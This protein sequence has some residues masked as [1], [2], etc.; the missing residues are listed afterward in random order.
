MMHS[1]SRRAVLTVGAVTMALS[2]L[3]ACGSSSSSAQTAGT[4]SNPISLSMGIEPWIGY[5]PWYIAQ[6][7]GYFAKHGLKVNIVNFQTDADRNAAL[8]SGKTEVS[9]IDAGR[10][11][12]FKASKQPGTP[13]F[14]LDASLGAD[15]I[16]AASNITDARGLVGK[17]VDYEYGTTSD[18]LLHYY[19]L[20]NK[21]NPN[22]VKSNNVPAANAGT[23]LIAGKTPVAVTYQPYITN[24]TQGAN[25]SKA[26]ILFGSDKA[27]GLISDFVTA[28]SSWLASHQ[29]VT[30][31]LLAAWDDAVNFYNTHHDQAVKIMAKGVGATPASLTSTL[32]G[33]KI[34]S[35][36]ENKK[37]LSDGTLAAGIKK[38]SDTYVSMGVLKKPLPFSTLGNFPVLKK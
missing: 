26:H 28:N 38:I 33:V 24:A 20:K 14:L 5:A 10:I 32:S 8:I 27:P 12:Q 30:P 9:N 4:S 21:V 6:D 34:F 2:S 22:Q 15:A 23:L 13:L 25:A 31:K 37:M 19:L 36:A 35:G 1:P 16:L 11:V 7:Q 29:N 17:Q 18:L 3:T